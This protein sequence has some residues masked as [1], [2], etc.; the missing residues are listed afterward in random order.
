MSFTFVIVFN[1]NNSQ[2][3]TTDGS[4]DLTLVATKAFGKSVK[5]LKLKRKLSRG[6]EKIKMKRIKKAPQLL[7]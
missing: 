4:S 7:I 3:S 2:L 5:S 1:L 6:F